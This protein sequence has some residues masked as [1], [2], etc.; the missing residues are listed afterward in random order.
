MALPR[1]SEKSAENLLSAIE[2]SKE[3]P[4]HRLLFALGIRHV[5]QRTSYVLASELG[6][7][8]KIMKAT[9]NELMAIK[10][11]GPETARSVIYAFRQDSMKKLLDKLF[12]A[13]LKAVTMEQTKVVISVGP[14]TGKTVVVT[15]AIHGMTRSQVIETITALG[16]TVS[17]SVSAKTGLLIVG[18]NP[19][20]KLDKA[21]ALNVPIVTE[22]K[23]KEMLL[24]NQRGGR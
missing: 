22:N 19:G 17:S 14:L 7:I 20:S 24:N 23:F 10:D 16:G 15:G 21:K 9:E 6:S 2:K 1:R 12:R 5:G 3:Q 13:G 11:I 4:L 18:E 8:E